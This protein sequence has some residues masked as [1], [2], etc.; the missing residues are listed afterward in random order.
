MLKALLFDLDGTL[1]DTDPIHFQTWRV[2]LLAYGLDIDPALIFQI[3]SFG[4]CCNN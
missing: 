4:N 3:H 1:A 2:L